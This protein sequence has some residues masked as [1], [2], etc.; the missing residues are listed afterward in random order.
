MPDF[1]TCRAWWCPLWAGPQWQIVGHFLA[2]SLMYWLIKVS[3]STLALWPILIMSWVFIIWLFLCHFY[4]L[5]KSFGF[6][7]ID[8]STGYFIREFSGHAEF[9]RT[10][11]TEP[12]YSFSVVIVTAK[13]TGIARLPPDYRSVSIGLYK[14]PLQY[15]G[16]KWMQGLKTRLQ[17]SLLAACIKDYHRGLPCPQTVNNEG[18]LMII[19]RTKLMK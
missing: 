10:D 15:S 13:N 8:V 17:A 3:V 1:L 18:H 19:I 9:F 11:N 2:S 7:Y 4:Y 12:I 5:L 16:L 14:K 6:I